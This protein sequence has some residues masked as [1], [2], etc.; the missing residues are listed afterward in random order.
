MRGIFSPFLDVVSKTLV[1]GIFRLNLISAVD[2]K[3]GTSLITS[4]P[5]SAVE[6]LG[7]Y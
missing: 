2:L 1:G 5:N 6:F 4:T 7:L 3:H